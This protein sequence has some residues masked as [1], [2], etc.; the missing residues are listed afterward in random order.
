[1]TTIKDFA[2]ESC[3]DWREVWAD[4]CRGAAVAAARHVRNNV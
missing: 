4:L 1:M 3:G 2:A